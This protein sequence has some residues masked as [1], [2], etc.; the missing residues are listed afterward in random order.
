MDSVET[1]ERTSAFLAQLGHQIRIPLNSIIGLTELALR[2][3]TTAAGKEYLQ[4]IVDAGSSLKAI[5]ND[6]SLVYA[7]EPD[8]QRS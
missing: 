4:G 2:E 1:N 5:A 6:L 7:G 3:P 8:F